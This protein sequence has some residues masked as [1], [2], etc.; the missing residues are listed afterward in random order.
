ML[1]ICK[2]LCYCML[3]GFFSN[4]LLFIEK[5]DF[6]AACYKQKTKEELEHLVNESKTFA[7]F[8]RKLGYESHKG[9]SSSYL[10]KYLNEIGVDI[11]KF[12]KT[13]IYNFSHPKSELKDVLVNESTYTNLSSL[14][15]RILQEGL[16]EYKCSECG[17]TEWNGKPIVLQLDHIN[18]DNRDHR[19]E[20]LRLLCPNCHSQTETYSRKKKH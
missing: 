20:N 10:R 16:I 13:N 3:G 5:E 6:M 18:G 17:I 7:E 4:E 2:I 19:L 15:K 12:S 8:M 9:A 1:L 14:K 11:S